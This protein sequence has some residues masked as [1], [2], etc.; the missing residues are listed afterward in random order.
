[1]LER[2]NGTWLNLCATGILF[3]L[4][5]LQWSEHVNAQGVLEPGND[6]VEVPR[7]TLTEIQQE[8]EALRARD[9]E[10]QAWEASIMNRLPATTFQFSGTESESRLIGWDRDPKSSHD[11]SGMGAKS[12]HDG[13]SCKSC[14]GQWMPLEAP[15]V[16]CPRV[17]TLSPYFNVNVFGALKLDMLFNNARPIAPGT[18]FFLAPDSL[19]GLR[20]DT[21]DIHARQTTLGAAL[22]GPQVGAF[23]SGGLVLAMLYNDAVIVDQYGFLPLQAYGELRNEDWR[24]AAGL[25]FDVFSPGLPTVLPFSALAAS[26]NAG[27]AFRGQLRLERFLNPTNDRQW[28]LQFALSEPIVT[29]IDPAFGLSEDNGWPNVEGR[30]AWGHGPAELVGLEVKRPF[31][32]GV[33]G[34]VGQNRTTRQNPNTLVIDRVIADVWGLSGDFRWK[35]NDTFGVMG[36]FYTGQTLGTYNAGIL[37]SVNGDTLDGV[38]TTGGWAEFFVYL[39]P[40]LHSHTGYAIDDPRDTDL[41]TAAISLARARNQTLYTNLLWDLNAT[42][43]VGFEFTWRKTDYLFAGIPDNEGPGFHTQFQWAF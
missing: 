27:N 1:M 14:P 29:T 28:T 13:Y 22:T 23:Q 35:I 32:V 15:C 6:V 40:C 16:D 37:Q 4:L 20:Q 2:L 11:Q 41:A 12:K 5:S 42:F 34:V 18:P 33:S 36:E 31:E 17:S 39:T 10:R 21:F 19:S 26:G 30:V 24:F 8:L 43:R 9:L 38:R 7:R 3:V 25:Q